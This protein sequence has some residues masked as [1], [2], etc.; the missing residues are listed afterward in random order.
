M[1]SFVSKE[2]CRFSV[3][4]LC[5]LPSFSSSLSS[6]LCSSHYILFG[7]R[8]KKKNPKKAKKNIEHVSFEEEKKRTT[9]LTDI[10]SA[11]TIEFSRED[12]HVFIVLH[13]TPISIDFFLFRL[14]IMM[15]LV[16]MFAFVHG[17]YSLERNSSSNF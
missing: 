14:Q 16:G 6:Y 8:T 5:F 11:N 10:L 9:F 15:K 13:N 1:A 4:S 17:R 3:L 12:I 7:F 2:E